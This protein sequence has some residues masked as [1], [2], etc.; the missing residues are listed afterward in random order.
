M[1]MEII[2]PNKQIT[3]NIF[4]KSEYLIKKIKLFFKNKNKII[5]NIINPP[6]PEVTNISRN[7]FSGS[8]F[9]DAFIKSNTP[10]PTIGS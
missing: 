10:E 1:F 2:P 4:C 5:I 8:P 7:K 9:Q 3:N 6:R